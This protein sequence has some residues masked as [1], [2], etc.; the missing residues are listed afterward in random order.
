MLDNL[1]CT[2]HKIKHMNQEQLNKIDEELATKYIHSRIYKGN[3]TSEFVNGMNIDYLLD[4]LHS[5]LQEVYELGRRDERE[6]IIEITERL[7]APD[8]IDDTCEF[9]HQGYFKAIEDITKLLQTNK[10]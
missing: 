7:E 6:S 2:V 10:E 3:T 1:S 8:C 4:F 5:K 9:I